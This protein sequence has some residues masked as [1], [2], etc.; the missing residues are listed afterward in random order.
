MSAVSDGLTRALNGPYTLPLV[1]DLKANHKFILFSDQHKG[2]G[3]KADEFRKCKE[4][5]AAALNH[6]REAGYTLILLGDVEELWEQSFRKVEATYRDILELE[7]SFPAGRYYRIWGNHDDD[8]MHPRAVNRHLAKYMP[9]GAVFEGIRFEVENDSQPLGTIL[10]LHGHQGTFASDKFRFISR[11][12][13]RIYRYIQRWTGIGKT[14]PAEE[15]CLR[16]EH[17][18]E[19][20]D[21]A[22][23]QCELD[24]I[25]IAGHTHRPVWSSRTHL[26]KLQLQ[27]EA[28]QSGPDIPGKLELIQ[29]KEA[30]IKRREE[31]Y[32]PCDDVMKTSP[33]YF[34]TG[35]CRFDDGDITGIE[36][37]N[38]MISLVKWSSDSLE[39]TVFEQD[40]L[41]DIFERIRIHPKN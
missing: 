6:Y 36:I 39:K 1:L 40:A 24:L 4:T 32:P 23:R 16:S 26:Q 9:T 34:N 15:V 19:M 18:N 22:H 30:A 14:T 13:I 29:E 10:L 33:V 25:L 37:D 31:K 11:F 35:C 12:F 27:L 5:Y 28:L 20:Y 41:T 7:G 17:D 38:G 2:A 21:W 8:W 3:D